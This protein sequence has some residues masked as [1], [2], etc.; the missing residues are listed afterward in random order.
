MPAA[1]L[2]AP[3]FAAAA[4][5]APK[6]SVQEYFEIERQSEIRYEYVEGELIAMPG[7]SLPHND[8]TVNIGFAI[9]SVVEVQLNFASWA[10]RGR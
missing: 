8:I 2:I 4:P 3:P 9:N 1:V 7:V 5:S 6:I 10:A